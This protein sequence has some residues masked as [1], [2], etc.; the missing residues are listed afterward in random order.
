MTTNRTYLSSKDSLAPIRTTEVFDYVESGIPWIGKIPKHWKVIPLKHL[1]V[2]PI[3][4]G[5]HETPE[6]FDHGIPF[7][8]AEAIK[9]GK[10]DFSKIRGFISLA[11]HKKYS[12][13]YKPQKF[14]VF[15]IK[16]G[17]TTGN[18]AMVETDDE[19]NIW[20]PLAAIRAD[21]NKILPHYILY[22]VKSNVFITSVEMGWS[23]GTQQNIGMN[24][25]ENLP[26]VVPPLKE[27]E[28]ICMFLSRKTRLIDEL[29]EKKERQIELLNEKRQALIS[30]AVTKGFDNA[31]FMK[32]SGVEWIGLI[33]ISWEILKIASVAQVVR[34]ASP[35]PAGSPEYFNGNDTPWITVAD[36]TKDNEKYLTET[37]TYLTREGEKFSRKI[38]AGTLVLS[39]SGATLG[40]PKILKISGCINDGSV[41]FLKLKPHVSIDFFF[42][43][44]AS[45]TPVF[46]ERIKQ[47]SGQPNLNTEI[48]KT[49]PLAIPPIDEQKR[50][51]S[52]LEN[53]IEKI[54]NLQKKVIAQVEKMNEYR[55][56]IISS[57]MTGQISVNLGE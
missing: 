34:G 31:V 51:V 50:I 33:P 4:D 12:R 55:A 43:Y 19:F 18:S 14:D 21:Y 35:R 41:A 32:E 27:Q 9:N 2:T 10:I 24:V 44:L 45:M 17:A 26:L 28:A 47:G 56:T 42:Y 7:V 6:L 11:D 30:H 29:I 5:P 1:V 36:I 20:S 39:N 15:I 53:E 46:R 25:I 40:V 52:Q 16:S 38:F 54:N 8:S 48:V 23:F 22:F 49:T 57:A 3:T 37:A 13:K